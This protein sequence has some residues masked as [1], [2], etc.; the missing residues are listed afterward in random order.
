MSKTV[1][2]AVRALD[3]LAESPRT[4]SELARELDVHSSTA[5][6]MLQPLVDSG[7]IARGADGNYRLGLRLAE[8][9]Q[10]VLDEID[11]RTAARPQLV[12][13]AEEVHATVHLA[14]LIDDQISYVDKIEGAAS[15][16]TWSR[17]GRA[18]P[19][20]T[21]AV[22]KV[23]LATLP[24]WR[25]EQL[26]AGHTFTRY[27]EHTITSPER[28]RSRLAE[29]VERGYAT[30]DGEFEPLVHCMAVPI[31]DASRQVAAAVSVTT[32]RAAPEPDEQRD[33][34][35]KLRA[36]AAAIAGQLGKPVPA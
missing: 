21:A 26:L 34:V 14:Q 6:R 25:R 36:T 9:G 3:T 11:L 12:K 1:G 2:K 16:R 29:A 32:V 33:L 10:Q 15:V 17:A 20:H 19:L 18:V 28:L 35:E 13:L 5:L 4:I 22:S 23:I 7:L 27:T 30:D 31:P 8:L 24:E